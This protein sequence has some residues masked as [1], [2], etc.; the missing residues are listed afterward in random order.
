MRKMYKLKVPRMLQAC[1]YALKCKQMPMCKLCNISPPT[2]QK[3]L[4][5]K[6]ISEKIVMRIIHKT[7]LSM[8]DFIEITNENT[9][10]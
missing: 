5:G 4:K 9:Q 1:M 7:G 10:K 6:A 8:D 3:V 2:L